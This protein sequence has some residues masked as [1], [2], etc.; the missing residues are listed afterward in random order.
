MLSYKGSSCSIV[1]KHLRHDQEALGL[2]I[3]EFEA[4]SCFYPLG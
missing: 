4:F 3:V 1:V 2:N